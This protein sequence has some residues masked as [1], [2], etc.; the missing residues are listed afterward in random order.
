MNVASSGNSCDVEDVESAVVVPEFELESTAVVD[1]ADVSFSL[2]SSAS[3][4][5]SRALIISASRS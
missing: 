3:L 5:I 4:T 2:S 1:V